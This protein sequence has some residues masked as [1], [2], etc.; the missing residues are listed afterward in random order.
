MKC[1]KAAD[2]SMWKAP[3]EGNCE[4]PRE[5]R[6]VW[7]GPLTG[8]DGGRPFK[9]AVSSGRGQGSVG[10]PLTG[11]CG[12][13]IEGNHEFPGEAMGVQEGC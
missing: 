6:G 7:E 9:G 5:A 10:R 13:H 1:G 3:I 12:G 11:A 4:F 8:A 2:R